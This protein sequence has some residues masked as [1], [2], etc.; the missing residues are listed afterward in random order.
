VVAESGEIPEALV[1]ISP[2]D[3]QDLEIYLASTLIVAYDTSP[4]SHA[5]A[6][7]GQRWAESLTE[8]GVRM[9]SMLK[10]LST[11]KRTGISRFRRLLMLLAALSIIVAACTGGEAESP[12][13]TVAEP[14]DTTT[15]DSP[16]PTEAPEEP[17]ELQTLIVAEPKLPLG[18]DPTGNTGD[19]RPISQYA[20][21]LTTTN[22]SAEVVPALAESWEI[23]DDGIEYTFFL[24]EGV[25]F[26]NGD[27][28]TADDVIWSL[29]R[30]MD[31]DNQSRRLSDMTDNIATIEAVDDLTLR[32]TLQAPFAPFLG[33]LVDTFIVSP[34]SEM[35]ADGGITLPI[36]TG[37][38][39]FVEWVPDDR[40][41]LEK[42]EDY[43]RPGVPKV[44]RLEILVIP[45]ETARVAALRA[46]DV[47]AIFGYPSAQVAA[48]ATS[49]DINIA[50]NPAERWWAF[51]FNLDSLSAPFDNPNI[52]KAIAM[53]VD[54]NALVQLLK[55]GI[56]NTTSE[57]YA[58]GQFWNVGEDDPYATA[59]PDGARAL[60]A[61]EGA[62]GLTVRLIAPNGFDF[63]R[64]VLVLAEQLK[65]AGFNP[66]VELSEWASFQERLEVGTDW[67]MSVM[68]VSFKLDPIRYFTFFEPGSTD[69]FWLGGGWQND[70]FL[71]LLDEAATNPDPEARKALYQ[72]AYALMT[73]EVP[74]I[75]IMNDTEIW[76]YST[77]LAG[78]TPSLGEYPSI[79]GG[80]ALVS[81]ED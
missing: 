33:T 17:R 7:A 80:F 56:A 21:G 66:V 72:Q 57:F 11:K 68:S 14:T 55:F 76:A 25:L 63:D 38:F 75:L 2:R 51:Q 69:S 37:P 79:D 9:S 3:S 53:A 62:E 5:T 50:F 15:V 18:I 71:S 31:P 73:D 26:H 36:A 81:F 64:A 60:L 24:R 19:T 47:D 48:A 59:D 74:T 1:P 10:N 78:F 22:I 4:A 45:D 13:D 28:F 34:A 40:L 58:D 6:V 65:A 54:K 32:I 8:L 42:F 20:E 29:E 23:S 12:E 77:K 61:A 16:D 39:K 52:R 27:P 43:W 49:P 70:D 35:D 46:G 67:D 41:V 44:D 30:I